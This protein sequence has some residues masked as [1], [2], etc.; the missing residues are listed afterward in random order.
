M[1]LIEQKIIKPDYIKSK[2]KFLER[3]KIGK[4]E[5]ASSSVEYS[6]FSAL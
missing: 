2:Q 4:N 1:D 3:D 5:Y 6:R